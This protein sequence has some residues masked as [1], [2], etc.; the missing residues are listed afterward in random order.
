MLKKIIEKSRTVPK[1]PKV[2]LE[3]QILKEGPS[4]SLGTI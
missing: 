2:T 4:A 3:K 1:N